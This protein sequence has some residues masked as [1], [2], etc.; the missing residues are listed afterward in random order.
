M[1][2]SCENFNQPLNSWD[3]SNV[4]FKEAMFLD[5]HLDKNYL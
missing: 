1:F 3:T 5:C 2:A 4:E